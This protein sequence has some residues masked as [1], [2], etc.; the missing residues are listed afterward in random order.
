MDDL[1][2]ENIHINIKNY[3][4]D[5]MLKW[6]LKILVKYDILLKLMSL[7]SFPFIIWA[8][9]EHW[10]FLFNHLWMRIRFLDLIFVKRQACEFLSL[11]FFFSFLLFACLFS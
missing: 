8:D 7:I 1:I 6:Y 3:Y 11:S 2:L 9:K 10:I 5:Y 4:I